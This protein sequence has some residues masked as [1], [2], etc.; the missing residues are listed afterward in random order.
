MEKLSLFPMRSRNECAV[1]PL[2]EATIALAVKLS[3]YLSTNIH[4]YSY[5]Q[6]KSAILFI[7]YVFFASRTEIC[8]KEVELGDTIKIKRLQTTTFV[9]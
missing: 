7:S 9:R 5:I 2:D 1:P 4:S 3:R 8:V 6:K